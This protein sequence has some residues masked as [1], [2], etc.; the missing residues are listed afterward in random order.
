MILKDKS[1]RSGDPGREAIV[2]TLDFQLG[3]LKRIK[4]NKIILSLLRLYTYFK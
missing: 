3:H 2:K 4:Q 1:R